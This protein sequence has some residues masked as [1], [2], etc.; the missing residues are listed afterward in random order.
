MQH[1][2]L[3][4]TV[5]IDFEVTRFEDTCI[6]LHLLEIR[7]HATLSCFVGNDRNINSRF[8]GTIPV[9]RR[10]AFVNGDPTPVG[11]TDTGCHMRSII[12]IG[13]HMRTSCGSRIKMTAVISLPFLHKVF[14]N[15]KVSFVLITVT[16]ED[17]GRMITIFIQYCIHFPLEKV[18]TGRVL[19]YILDPHRKFD[20]QIQ[21]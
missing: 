14:E 12:L 17:K 13:S 5:L 21:S 18:T 1:A 4:E 11:I 15:S 19:P 2:V 10:F 8:F 6:L 9:G 3:S 7:V 20:L 16:I